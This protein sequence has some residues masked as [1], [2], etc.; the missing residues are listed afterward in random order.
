MQMLLAAA[1]ALALAQHP[2]M[3]PGMT[4][5]EHQAQ[6][7]K[8][9]ELA[10]RGAQAMGFDQDAAEHHFIVTERGGY[11][12]VEARQG[13]DAATRDAIRAHLRRIAQEFAQGVFEKPS[14]T[15]G[16][17]PDGVPA[18]QRLASAIGYRYEERPRGGR[19]V[20]EASGGE[21]VAAVHEFLRYQIREHK[22]GDPK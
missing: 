2:S 4:H 6:I 21:A 14:A 8:D 3:P 17:I 22:T 5:E 10:A 11:I 13:A 12:Q 18:M 7:K 16:E 15:H 20:I 9:A 19:V 1:A